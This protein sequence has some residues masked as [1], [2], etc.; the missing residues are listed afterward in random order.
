[1][2]CHNIN[3]PFQRQMYPQVGTVSYPTRTAIIASPYG[4][5]AASQQSLV[6][7]SQQPS[8]NAGPQPKQRVFTGT[9]TKVQ[10]NFGFV[11][12]EVFFQTRFVSFMYFYYQVCLRFV[13]LM[14]RN[15]QMVRVQGIVFQL[16]SSFFTK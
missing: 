5:T 16:R 15:I 9:V 12:E 11:D 13:F 10:D 14:R 3:S 1:M 7:N 6:S 8:G 2:F 4:A